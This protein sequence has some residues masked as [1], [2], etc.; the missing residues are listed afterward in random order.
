MQLGASKSERGV[1]SNVPRVFRD[2]ALV[3]RL[4]R[5]VPLVLGTRT[6]HTFRQCSFVPSDG[7]NYWYLI[8]YIRYSGYLLSQSHFVKKKRND[9]VNMFINDP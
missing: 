2:I 7:T 4:A 9:D 8:I 3:P 5:R 6:T 1:G